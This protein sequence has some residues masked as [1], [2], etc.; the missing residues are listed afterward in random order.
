MIAGANG[1]SQS[2]RA[3]H[4]EPDSKTISYFEDEKLV[5]PSADQMQ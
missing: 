2:H 5:V 1:G 3:T 4:N